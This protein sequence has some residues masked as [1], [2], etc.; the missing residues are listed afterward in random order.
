M[1]RGEKGTAYVSTRY[2]ETRRLDSQEHGRGGDLPWRTPEGG[3][4]KVIAEYEEEISPEA[5]WYS[6]RSDGQALGS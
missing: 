4:E 2:P 6:I 3:T 1:M 5:E